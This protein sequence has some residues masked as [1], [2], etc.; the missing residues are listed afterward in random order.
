MAER[1]TRHTREEIRDL[2]M[3]AGKSLL[4]EEGLGT[5][6]EGL[7]FKK[8]FGHVEAES[9]IRLTN[10]SI[11]GRLWLNLADYQ[12]DVLAAI[13]LEG[14]EEE[15]DLTVGAVAPVLDNADLRTPE[16][17]ER[18]I[19]DLCRVGGAANMQAVRDSSNWPLWINVWGVATLG[20]ESEHRKKIEVALTSGYENFSKR[21][22][23]VYRAVASFLGFRIRDPLTLNQFSIAADSLGQGFG[24]RD[25][26]D[27]SNAE[28]IHRPTGP[29][30]EQ[31]E[32]TLFALAFEAL[33]FHFFE[34]DPDWTGEGASQ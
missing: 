17:R 1:H 10:A 20:Q 2:L 34:I 7:T 28:V 29:A 18:T 26:F 8:V 13:A 14:N 19:R 27:G 25:R 16:L 15:I 22:E 32:W 11:I 33:V 5:G 6:A 4:H 3:S 9:G 12:S 30:G 23:E 31:Q 24:L 21:I